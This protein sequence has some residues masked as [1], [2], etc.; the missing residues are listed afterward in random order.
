MKAYFLA[1]WAIAGV[2]AT[3]AECQTTTQVTLNFNATVNAV[4]GGDGSFSEITAMVSVSPFGN[5]SFVGALSVVTSC[6]VVHPFT[7][8]FPS[9][10]S[11]QIPS[12][13]SVGGGVYVESEEVPILGGTGIFKN[14]TGSLTI[15]VSPNGPDGLG[16]QDGSLPIPGP[17]CPVNVQFT[18]SGSITTQGSISVSPSALRFS[19][20]QGSSTPSSLTLTLTNGTP[21]PAAFSA[22]SSGQSW[23]SV[24]PANSTAAA[25]SNTTATVTVNPSGLTPGTYAGTVTLATS[26]QQFVAPVTV[27]V[28]SAPLALAISQTALR[29]QAAAGANSPASQS[30]TVLNEGKGSL[31]WSATSSTPVGSWLSVSPSNGATGQAA[32]VSVDPTG[33]APGDYY[34]LVQFA[35]A[36]AANSPQA[37]VVVVNVLLATTAVPTV[38]PTGLIFAGQRGGSN[39]AAQT[40]T[41]SN[42][43]N[44]SIMVA[45]N[46]LAQQNGVFSVTPS[47]TTTVTSSPASQFTISADLTGL[48]TGVYPGVVQFLFGD[49]SVQQVALVLIVTPPDGAAAVP[50]AIRANTTATGCTPTELLPISIALGQG[51]SEVAAWPT[52]L[53]IQVV[54]DCG[55]PMGPGTV[56]ASF[57]DGDPPLSLLSLGVGM[58]SGTW[59]PRYTAS[60]AVVVITVQA[61]SLQPALTGMVQISGTL[62]PNQSAPA[63]NAG[64]AVSAA[65]F[66]ANGPLAPGGF[67]SIFG[68]NF[69]SARSSAG[70]LPLGTTLGGTQ[71]ILG[72]ESMPLLF[73]S[74]GQINA[75]VPYG[76]APNATQQLIVQQDTAYSMPEA[77][78][79]AAAQPGVFTQDQSGMGI[80]VIVVVQPDGTLFE[81][82][83][84]HPATAGD[85]LVIYCA[86]LGAVNPLVAAGAAAP[87]SPLAKASNTVTVTI[88]NQPAQ[89]SFAGLTPTFAGLY[90]VNVL[91]PPGITPGPDV[92]V[93]LTQGQLSGPP[94]TIP[95]Q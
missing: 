3:S 72:G 30:I 74:S 85:S 62:N 49:G 22:T 57:S 75:I 39:P 37:A 45:P 71:A 32:T 77:V 12:I 81:I 84:S 29:F 58:W 59:E 42:P 8:T 28:S 93:V 31:N 25:F 61:Q 80:G 91:V 53:I 4:D 19:F 69:A 2:L 6:C 23:L 86:G 17:L 83:A 38:E 43:S 90:Q 60:A 16:C 18:A 50:A 64:G 24:S 40:V 79:V 13:I 87:T 54:D 94:V 9:G 68:T 67:T 1:A 55:N 92:P 73:T 95:I 15:V 5:A 56:V 46:L 41:I 76:I 78:T 82:D 21:Q 44:E 20:L 52:P 48:T 27:T 47:G 7:F 70:T 89:V 35:S 26:G 63:I 36:G 34:G 11:F 51:F 33:L 10:D 14:A 88:G 65:S 66:A